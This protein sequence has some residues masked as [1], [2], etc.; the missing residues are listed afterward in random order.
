MKLMRMLAVAALLASSHLV[1]G[2]AE[3]DVMSANV[4]FT[5]TA[6]G[7]SMPPGHYVISRVEGAPIW[8][9]QTFGRSIYVTSQTRALHKTP[10]ASS[11]LFDRDATGYTLTQ[12]QQRAQDE[13]AQVSAPRGAKERRSTTQQ[14]ASVTVPA[15]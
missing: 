10:A 15:R 4:P 7:V 5:F 12:F 13:A 8:K 11:L 1:Y 3:T 9:L 2:Q 6:G 14:V